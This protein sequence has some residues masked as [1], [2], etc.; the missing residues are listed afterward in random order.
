MVN[1][2]LHPIVKGILSILAVTVIGF[3]LLNVAFLFDFLF[4]SVINAIV[5]L[6]TPLNYDMTLYWYPP[7]KHGLFVVLIGLIS[8]YVFRSKLCTLC[9]AIYLVVP[10]ATVLLTIG[11]FTYQWPALSIS[12]GV[13]FTI[14]VLWDLYRTKQ[15]WIYYYS[16]IAMALI[17][18]MVVIFGVEI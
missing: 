2:T 12:L 18:L 3:F 9:K 6:F 5:G 8:W 17:M 10:M 7:L 15:P 4:Q 1:I 13:V 16:V 14:S 11:I